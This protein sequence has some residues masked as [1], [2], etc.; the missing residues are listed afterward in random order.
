M[1]SSHGTDP[2]ELD[3]DELVE[4]LERVRG[5]LTAAEER[6]LRGR[7]DLENYR[8]RAD[9]EL[10]RRVR[11]EGD[12]LLRAW[13]E[14]V[15]SLDRASALEAEH[16]DLA[17]GVRAFLDQVETLLARQGVSRIGAVG[18][19]FDPELHEAVAIVPADGAEDGRVAQ[20]VRSGY[21]AGDRVI[22]PA[23]V[24]VARRHDAG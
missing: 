10:E 19:A 14:V 12:E 1:Q 16:P 2:R 22:R 15:D 20:V 18:D 8:K 24:A 17:A 7:A 5:D 9:R 11:E 23:Q 13:L 3:R 6:V 21:A 4:E